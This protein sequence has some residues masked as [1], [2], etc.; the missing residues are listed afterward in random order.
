MDTNFNV[1]DIIVL[2]G[3]QQG[4][5]PLKYNFHN[6]FF[7]EDIF[8]ETKIKNVKVFHDRSKLHLTAEGNRIIAEFLWDKLRDK[9]QEKVEGPKKPVPSLFS[10][11]PPLSSLE[12]ES[13]LAA[14]SDCA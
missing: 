7:V 8:N 6:Q 1:D 3:I 14:F 11:T 13:R 4:D 2:F 10:T 9:L 12:H 5:I